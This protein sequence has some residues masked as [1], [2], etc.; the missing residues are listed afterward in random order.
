MI[1]EFRRTFHTEYFPHFSFV[2]RNF[3]SR[4]SRGPGASAG[5]G[6][7]GSGLRP[8]RGPP[9]RRPQKL[10]KEKGRPSVAEASPKPKSSENLEKTSG[11]NLAKFW[12][13][14]PKIWRKSG[15]NLRKSPKI[16]RKSGQKVVLSSLFGQKQNRNGHLSITSFY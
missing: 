12:R 7:S 8:R 16:W 15:E 4:R 2:F 1:T 5:S 13:K 6:A 11:E 10:K 14:S 3:C 9:P